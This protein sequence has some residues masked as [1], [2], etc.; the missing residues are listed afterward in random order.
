MSTD[1]IGQLPEPPRFVTPKA[2]VFELVIGAGR[3]FAREVRGPDPIGRP[4]P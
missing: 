4:R 1:L 3:D 2:N